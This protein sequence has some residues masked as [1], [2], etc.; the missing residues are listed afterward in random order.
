MAADEYWPQCRWLRWFFKDPGKPEGTFVNI[1]DSVEGQLITRTFVG[2]RDVDGTGV[3]L[4][5]ALNSHPLN[6]AT[7]IIV[8]EHGGWE[9]VDRIALDTLC[10]TYS[11]DPLFLMSHFYWDHSAHP[12]Q[13]S[14][15]TPPVS[16]PISLPSLVSFLSLDYRGQFSGLLLEDISPQT[17]RP[18]Y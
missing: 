1:L 10:S 4:D 12:K 9:N 11:I 14:L 18:F 6:I 16:P 13:G 3:S 8:V 15:P 2:G 7:R 17:G 5:S